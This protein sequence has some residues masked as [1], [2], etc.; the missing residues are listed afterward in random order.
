PV[1]TAESLASIL[2]ADKEYILN[3][4]NQGIENDKSQVEFGTIGKGIPLQVKD[5][6]EAMKLPGIKFIKENIR[7]YPN[8]EFASHIIGFAQKID[9]ETE[10]GEIQ[11]NI[12]ITGIEHEMNDLLKG[13]DGFISY[14]R[15]IYNK[16]LL[17]PDE[18]L[19]TPDN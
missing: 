5:E 4:I 3:Q 1:N 12:G 2:D 9:K 17:H 13:E 19:T 10:N 18:I 6:I 14:Q 7:Y 16:R 11:E 8:G 15:N